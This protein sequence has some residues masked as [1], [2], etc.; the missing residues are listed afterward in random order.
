VAT[1]TADLATS[2]IQEI[3]RYMKIEIKDLGQLERYNG[4]D[5]IQSKYN[6]KL[7]NPTYLRKIIGEHQWMINDTTVSNMPTPMPDDRKYMEKIE[8]AVAPITERDRTVLQLKMNFNYRQAIGELIYAM[9]TCRPDISYPLIKLSQYSQNPAEIHYNAVIDIF[10]YLNATID[11]GL[12]FWRPKPN[13]YLP[14]LPL[15]IVHKS[16][17][18]TSNTSDVDSA[19]QMHSAVDSDWAGDTKHRK[20]VSGLILRLSGGTILYKTKYQDTIA[21][22]TTEAEFNAAC[23]A[24]K[25]I[26]YVRSILDEINLPQ[27]QSTTLFIDNN[28]ALM[29]GNAQQPTR[30]TRHIDLKKFALLDWIQHDLLIM[31]RIS[32]SDNSS[33]G[34]TKQTARQLFY[35]HFDYILGKCIPHYVTYIDEINAPIAKSTAINETNQ[36]TIKMALCNSPCI[37]SINSNTYVQEHGG[38]IIHRELGV[39]R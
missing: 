11:D 20:S 30:R 31:K 24:G 34:L 26:L 6:I 7:N 12:I 5:I 13:P 4:V 23:E 8:N 18:T 3:D 14:A 32:T 19:T 22:S 25:S 36:A 28:G 10:R 2:I 38:D 35:R 21:L 17:Y 15:P 33:D 37:F 9:V 1:E 27:E 16:T 29:M 39:T